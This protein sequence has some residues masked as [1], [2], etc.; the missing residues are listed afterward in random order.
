MHK[1]ALAWGK[2]PSFWLGG[3]GEWTDHDRIFTHAVTIYQ[4]GLCSSCGMPKTQCETTEYEIHTNICKPEATVE[5]WRKDNPDPPPG[6]KVVPVVVSDLQA[7]QSAAA[8]TAP[9]W[10]KQKMAAQQ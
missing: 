2:P 5:Q 8:Q 10:V 6:T 3:D 1:T 4:A 7:S 9:D